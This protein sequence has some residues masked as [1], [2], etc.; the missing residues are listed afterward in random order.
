MGRISVAVGLALVLGGCSNTG[1]ESLDRPEPDSLLVDALVTLQLA[2]IRAEQSR[3]P[4]DSLRR[5]AYAAIQRSSRL[6]STAIA[7]AL[8]RAAHDPASAALLYER[9]ADRL[10]AELRGH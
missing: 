2:D 4:A 8:T 5:E 6:D 1:P 7:D 3:E 9:V 10:T